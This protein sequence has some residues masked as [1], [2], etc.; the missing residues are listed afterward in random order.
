MIAA[1]MPVFIRRVMFAVLAAV[2]LAASAAGLGKLTVLSKI[3]EPLNAEID[4]VAI[5]AD[6]RDSLAASLAPPEAFGANV[7]PSPRGDIVRATIERTASGRYVLRLTS[8]EPVNQPLVDLLLQLSWN[9]GRL[10]RQYTFLLTPEDTAPTLAVT[11]VPPPVP[12]AAEELPKAATPKP[13]APRA[14]GAST[15]KPA[16]PRAQGAATHRVQPGETLGKI[17]QAT[18]RDGTSV[19]RM[20]VAIFRANPHAFIEDNLNL[21]RAGSLLTIPSPEDGAAIALEEAKRV[22]AESR[23]GFDDYRRRLGGTVAAGPPSQAPAPAREAGRAAAKPPAPV[24]RSDQL[25]LRGDDADDLAARER[26]LRAAR[27]RIAELEKALAQLRH[28]LD[29]RE[30]D[31]ET[32]ERNIEARESKL[33]P[34]T[35]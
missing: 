16:A 6:E 2:P 4:I 8:T 26:A 32:R 15:P 18:R 13:A 12:P 22:I 17:A 29:A 24:A 9:G 23:A 7:T 1:V 3:G 30:R 20:I 19:E 27:E 10:L 21:L 34:K 35:R 31:I 5:R 28:I 11:P 25:T 14:Q 33:A